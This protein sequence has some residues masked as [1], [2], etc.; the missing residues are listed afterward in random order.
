MEKFQELFRI[1]M[2]RRYDNSWH[3]THRTFFNQVNSRNNS[4]NKEK[5]GRNDKKINKKLKH[6]L[7]KKS[8]LFLEDDLFNKDRLL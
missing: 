3:R 5:K 8:G 4:K 1:N 2:V 6:T 7:T